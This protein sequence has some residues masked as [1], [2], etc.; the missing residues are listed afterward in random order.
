MI[1]SLV[2]LQPIIFLFSIMSPKL[3]WSDS[4]PSPEGGQFLSE[5]S[6]N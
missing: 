3:G 2:P 1:L 6:D 5:F 4:V